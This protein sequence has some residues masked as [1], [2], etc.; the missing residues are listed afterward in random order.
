MVENI[1]PKV[2]YYSYVEITERNHQ[3]LW[4]EYERVAERFPDYFAMQQIANAA[5]IYPVFRELFARK[6]AVWMKLN[7]DT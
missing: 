1:L 4:H 6:E 2:Q 7:E 5:D 3:S